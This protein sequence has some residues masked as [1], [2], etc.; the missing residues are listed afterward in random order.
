[1]A[2]QDLYIGLGSMAYALAK[3]DGRLQLEEVTAMQQV[4]RV[5]PYGDIAFYVFDLK[6]RYGESVE[7]AYQF[8]FRRFAENRRDL[9]PALKKNFQRVL[10]LI[11]NAY[12]GTSRKENELLRRFQRDINKL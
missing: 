1:M 6:E 12:D 8:A 2:Q 7:D 10:E 11:A 5:E 3:S 4:L 9:N